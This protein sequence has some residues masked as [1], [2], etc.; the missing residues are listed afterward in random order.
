MDKERFRAI[1]VPELPE[2]RTVIAARSDFGRNVKNRHVNFLNVSA[3]EVLDR[4][5]SERDE[6]SETEEV[7]RSLVNLVFPTSNVDYVLNLRPVMSRREKERI[8]SRAVDAMRTLAGRHGIV[9]PGNILGRLIFV[10]HET[11]K[12]LNA[13][14][15]GV[16]ED[17]PDVDG[18]AFK[19]TGV[20]D[21]ERVEDRPRY[22]RNSLLLHIGTHEL[23]HTLSYQEDWFSE[24][25]AVVNLHRRFGIVSSPPIEIKQSEFYRS[26]LKR[27]YEGFTEFLAQETLKLARAEGHNV[28][29]P[30]ELGV[31]NVLR[32]EIGIGPFFQANFTKRGYLS[33]ARA[34]ERVFGSQE[35][36]RKIGLLMGIDW[37]EWRVSEEEDESPFSLPN[38]YSLTRNF[39]SSGEFQMKVL[40][41]GASS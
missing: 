18:F 17:F 1:V 26:G 5:L 36:L 33:L 9:V 12:N 16:Y 27:L 2:P 34:M 39:I 4:V 20:V 32:S 11:F 35:A 29:Y 8:F 22:D 21:Y 14:E 24:S 13:Q 25:E 10:D 41:L 7:V 30:D 28:A 31:F 23:W 37:L 38:F 19:R 40:P 15:G 3:N 6:A